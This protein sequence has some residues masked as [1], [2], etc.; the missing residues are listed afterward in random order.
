VEALE[1]SGLKNILLSSTLTLSVEMLG[2]DVTVEGFSD[3]LRIPKKTIDL[4]VQF[5]AL[6]NVL[7][8]F[9][10]MHLNGQ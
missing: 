9:S 2:I 6:G 1:I 8:A 5:S 7:T 4:T 3:S 10:G